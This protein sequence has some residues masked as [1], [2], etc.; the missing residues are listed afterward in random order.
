MISTSYSFNAVNF[1]A[2]TL[3]LV[4]SGQSLINFTK[5]VM[6]SKF[7]DS[8]QQPTVKKV[9]SSDSLAQ[10]FQHIAQG[11]LYA[12][13][14][15]ALYTYSEKQF[16]LQN[17][18]NDVV[19]V[20]TDLNKCNLG[21]SQTKQEL[22]EAKNIALSRLTKFETYYKEA[23][24]IIS[25][26][27]LQLSGNSTSLYQCQVNEEKLK[28]NLTQNEQKYTDELKE[29]RIKTQKANDHINKAALANQRLENEKTE[30]ESK[31]NTTKF[32]NEQLQRENERLS[33][34][35]EQLNKNLGTYETELNGCMTAYNI[36]LASNHALASINKNTILE[37]SKLESLLTTCNTNSSQIARINNE[38]EGKI[39]NLTEDLNRLEQ[40]KLQLD[41]LLA[42]CNKNGSDLATL[43]KQQEEQIADLK[44]K[45]AQY[46]STKPQN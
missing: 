37:K 44:G 13:A 7:F 33:R 11:C 34:E 25:D 29:E 38:Q 5:G 24:L 28:N 31:L 26:L 18:Q 46:E 20:K 14:A 39:G 8:I 30:C 1:G 32:E 41:G 10:R 16:I 3:A 12:V 40:K 21:F 9:D 2:K 27:Q 15:F 43:N 45:L 19:N 6:G 22:E 35:I 17:C 4:L 42:T 36:T 23:V